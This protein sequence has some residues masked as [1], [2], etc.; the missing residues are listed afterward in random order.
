MGGRSNRRGPFDLHIHSL[1]LPNSSPG[2]RLQR[3][4]RVGKSAFI[5]A[6]VRRDLFAPAR[7]SRADLCAFAIHPADLMRAVDK[8]PIVPPAGLEPAFRAEH[9]RSPTPSTYRKLRGI[10]S[11]VCRG[12]RCC[13]VP[14]SGG[15]T[16]SNFL[17][18]RRRSGSKPFVT[19][20]R[21]PEYTRDRKEIAATKQLLL[22]TRNRRSEN[23]FISSY[24]ADQP[25]GPDTI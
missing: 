23:Y 19:P 7:A 13:P 6:V 2:F 20:K 8:P 11:I 4:L 25:P 10:Y 17:T 5:R 15:S 24:Q 1:M 21:S 3:C 16:G 9:Q 18:N 22:P 12:M 14:S